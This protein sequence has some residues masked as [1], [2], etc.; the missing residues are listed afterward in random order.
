MAIDSHTNFKVSLMNT[1][2]AFFS[3]FQKDQRGVT[4]IEYGLIAIAMA[5]VLTVA[6]SKD[7][8]ITKGLNEGYAK[9]SQSISGSV[10]TFK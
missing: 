6:F 3:K 9:I 10:S 1:M 4:A 2:R 5:G 8:S 7:G